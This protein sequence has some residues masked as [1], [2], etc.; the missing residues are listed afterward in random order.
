MCATRAGQSCKT[1][2]ECVSNSNCTIQLQ[3]ITGKTVPGKCECLF[4]YKDDGAGICNA[5]IPEVTQ[6]P[7]SNGNNL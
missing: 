7:F 6:L 4:G 5:Y 2:H 3:P 1:Y